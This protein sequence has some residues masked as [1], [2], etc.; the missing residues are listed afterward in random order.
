[1]A[2]AVLAILALPAQAQTVCKHFEETAVCNGP[3]GHSYM[4]RF[5]DTTYVTRSDGSYATIQRFGDVSVVS[6]SRPEMSGTVQHWG[7]T[8][9]S[10][11]FGG[12][13]TCRTV[14]DTTWCS[15]TGRSEADAPRVPDWTLG[16]AGA[17]LVIT[18]K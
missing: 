17:D 18:L 4:Q 1:M 6:D 15:W 2:F 3:E 7:D 9:V 8:S 13:S 12:N 16:A 11:L 5:G 10:V 14:D